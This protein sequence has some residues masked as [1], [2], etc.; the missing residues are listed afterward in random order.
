MPGVLA[1]LTAKNPLMLQ[2]A[3][4]DSYLLIVIINIQHSTFN[5]T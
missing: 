1:Y 2:R 3:P 4:G 5:I